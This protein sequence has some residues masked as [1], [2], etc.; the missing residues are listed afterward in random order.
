MHVVGGGDGLFDFL[1]FLGT[2]DAALLDTGQDELHGGVVLHSVEFMAEQQTELT[3]VVGAVGWQVMDAASLAD[4][5]GTKGLEGGEIATI[6]HAHT[7]GKFFDAGQ[8]AGPDDIVDVVVVSEEIVY[9]VVAVQHADKIF[10][11]KTEEIEKCTVLTE[12]IGVVGVVAGGFVV[13]LND[14][15]AMA[16]VLA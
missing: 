6:L 2:L 10:A 12:P 8:G 15:K 7:G 16:Y 9:S 1:D 13:A 3:L 14:D 4:G 11:L 5:L